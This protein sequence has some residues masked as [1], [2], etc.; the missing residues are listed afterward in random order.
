MID[1][2]E[3]VKDIL[4]V[5]SGIL[6]TLQLV[7]FSTIISLFLG[8]AFAIM[9]YN[10]IGNVFINFFISI[11]R[12]TPAILQLSFIYF[13]I[14]GLIGI[15]LDI[16]VAGSI[17]FGLNHAAYFA[18]IFRSGIQNIPRGQFE[19]AQS[20]QIPK[21]YMYKDIILPQVIKNTLPTMINE[22]ASIL[23]HTA[24]ISTIGGT[25]IMRK[26]HILSIQKFTYFTP[27]I[28]AGL[29]YQIAVLFLEKLSKKIEKKGLLYAKN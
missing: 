29:Y 9:K 18:E 17:A 23:K 19:A 2:N 1:F 25:D 21:Y 12:G 15:K 16:V 4:F 5:G 3:F 10:N 20:L 8:L 28:I 26:S 13:A 22:L 24:L 27:L 6:T 14:P 7:F 11:I